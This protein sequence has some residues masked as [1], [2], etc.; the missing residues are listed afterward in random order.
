MAND[1][2]IGVF[3]GT[4]SR[5]RRRSVYKPVRRSKNHHEAHGMDAGRVFSFDFIV[6]LPS[7]NYFHCL[8]SDIFI[9]Q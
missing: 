8:F 4:P 5:Q 6:F 1:R 7:L 2:K 3:G 9:L